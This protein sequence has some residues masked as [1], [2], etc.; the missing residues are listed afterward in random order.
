MYEKKVIMALLMVFVLIGIIYYFTIDS[1]KIADGTY[2]IVNNDDYPSAVL[3]VEDGTIRFSNIDLNEVFKEAI[4]KH[5]KAITEQ[6]VAEL[7]KEEIEDYSNLN[8]YFVDNAYCIDYSDGQ[9]SKTGTFNYQFTLVVGS[10]LGLGLEY[11][12]W[13]K[14]IVVSRQGIYL[15]FSL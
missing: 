7:T 4:E 8:K 1:G 3:V 9:F 5:V 14:S 2:K 10:L 13:N 15:Y 11:D 6:N 12:S